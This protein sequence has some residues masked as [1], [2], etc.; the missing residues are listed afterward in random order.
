MVFFRDGTIKKC[1]L[2]VY[3]EKLKPFHILLKKPECFTSV[4]IQTGGYGVTWDVNLN[5]SDTMLYRM[6]KRIP[7]SIADFQN[8]VALRVINA[9]EV[10]EILDCSRQNVIDLTKRDK[11]HIIKYSEKNTLYLKSEVLRRKWQ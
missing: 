10:A 6:G 2:K 8:F 1:D 7:L 5:L 4:Q 3:F 9:T 11:L